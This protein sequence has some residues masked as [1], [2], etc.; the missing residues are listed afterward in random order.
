MPKQKKD[1]FKA[2]IVK[3]IGATPTAERV[4]IYDRFAPQLDDVEVY[5]IF[6]SKKSALK[7]K[8]RWKNAEDFDVFQVK[9]PN[10]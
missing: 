2:W 8:N 3:R 4:E 7:W 6:P 1:Y 9:I 5:T 10:V